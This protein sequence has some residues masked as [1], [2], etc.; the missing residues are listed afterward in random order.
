MLALLRNSSDNHNIHLTGTFQRDVAWFNVFLDRFNGKTMIHHQGSPHIHAFVDASLSGVGAI[1]E[2]N[3]YAA[4]YPPGFTH[5]VTIVHLE[6]INI[7]VMLNVWGKYW[8]NKLVKIWCDNEAVVHILTSGKTRDE[9]LALY[10]R[11]IWLFI[12]THDIQ[13]QYCHVQGVNNVY[14]DR[15]SRWFSKDI[16][17]HIKDILQ[18]KTWYQVTQDCFIPNYDI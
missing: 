12:A 13:T 8:K 9:A 17:G 4:T 11:S 2:N 3:V 1:W 16:E 10:A 6:L 5:M 14:A 7:W 18:A 15:L